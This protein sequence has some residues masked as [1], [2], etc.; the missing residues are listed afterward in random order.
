MIWHSTKI[1]DVIDYLGS[2]AD[3][4]LSQKKASKKQK[5]FGYNEIYSA[6][7]KTFRQHLVEQLT[8]YTFIVGI[9][10]ALFYLIFDFV[11]MDKSFRVPAVIIFT[12]TCYIFV[13]ALVETLVSKRIIRN[14]QV[15]D[16]KV[17]VIRDGNEKS[18]GIKY[19][20][21]GDIIVLKEGDYIPADAR[22]IE[23]NNLRCEE[24]LVTGNVT[25][26]EKNHAYICPDIEEIGGR[27]N[28]I[29]AGCC[30]AFGECKAIVVDTGADTERGKR[31]T[32][33]LREENVITPIQ[34]KVKKTMAVITTA[35]IVLSAVFF[36][37]GM[38][39]G[40]TRFDWREFV[41]MATLLFSVTVP[42]SYSLLV[43][44]NI[45]FGMRRARRKQCK[46]K[47]V[48]HLETMC[49]TNVIICDKTG[50]LTQ[51]RM[52]VER[53]FVDGELYDVDKFAPENVASML[54][55]AA[56]SCDGDVKIDDFGREYHNGD[57]VET[58]I[59]ASAFRILKTD[60]ITLESQ[61]PR[62]GEIPLDSVRRLKTVIC[63]VDGKPFAIVK[64][65]ADAI[66][67]KCHDVD[68]QLLDEKI[69]ELS[70]QAYRVIGIAYK[71]LDELPSMP[72]AE[73]IE[74]DLTLCGLIAV[75]NLP[76]FDA[77]VELEEC[78]KLGIKTIMLTGDNLETATAAAK[79]L[80]LLTVNSICV[81]GE[82]LSNMGEA[83]LN[84]KFQDIVVYAN[85]SPEQRL[86]IVEKW[87]ALNKV[88]AITGDSVT[89]AISLKQAD[90]GCAMEL[91]GT[92]LAKS[93][94][95]LV[96]TDD[97][98][99]AIVK[100]IKEIKGTYLNIRK[101]LKQFISVSF[102]L[103]ISM[104]LGLVFYKTSVITPMLL[105]FAG[106]YFNS[107]SSFSIAFEPA[108]KK[109]L[110]RQIHRNEEV[111]GG[112]FALDVAVGIFAMVLA[113]LVAY[114]FGNKYGFGIEYYYTVF[115]SS[116][117]FLGFS[118]RSEKNFYTLEMF[119]N[120]LLDFAY[121]V[122]G[123]TLTI[124]VMFT[125]AATFLKIQPLEIDQVIK[126]FI[127][128]L[129]VPA[130]NEAYKFIKQKLFK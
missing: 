36:V 18:I 109:V 79:K 21:P 107:I 54:K 127:L 97:S 130:I 51:N 25:T 67:E 85:I 6:Q 104:I 70:K 10:A 23:S 83:E 81:D 119:R 31:I 87:Q 17:T 68:K 44:F 103:A 65:S 43:T 128:A 20:V 8:S 29:Y 24:A 113:S 75:A 126:C 99:T 105:V 111:M 55:I 30:V 117:I 76:R 40:R 64:G 110:K 77:K 124:M 121:V 42:C 15:T 1:N 95:E 88:V 58:A 12:L 63:V 50:T 116:A 123:L 71:Q 4:G 56:L 49:A 52:K 125:P 33:H 98:Y 90:V 53:A 28:M 92:Q 41:L 47:N 48:E 22:L 32:E 13:V 72:S 89:D 108:H 35:F 84:E 39:I 14:T 115:V 120:P 101:S 11:F 38:F 37:L 100:G 62:M 7:N 94:S 112:T 80:D 5:E 45:V 2:N 82:M 16:A 9:L 114:F 86:M 129:I 118:N 74:N 59:L 93:A 19:I 26:V 102:A 27:S 60:K 34:T 46:I 122:A 57:I 78:T 69:S 73:A 61:Y 66:I 91:S 96:I 3:N 106:L